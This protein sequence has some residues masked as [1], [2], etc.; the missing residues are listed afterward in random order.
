MDKISI[1][2]A[3]L[4]NFPELAFPEALLVW[5][6]R[7][8]VDIANPHEGPGG[9]LAMERLRTA[10]DH[11]RAP[12]VAAQLDHLWT[13]IGSSAKRQ[14]D[15]RCPGCITLSPDEILFVR[16]IACRQRRVT[17]G[18]SGLL[19]SLCPATARRVAA[20]FTQ[21]LADGLAEGRLLLPAR[22]DG[23]LCLWQ[24]R[25]AAAMA[26]NGEAEDEDAPALDDRSLD[27]T[28][29]GRVITLH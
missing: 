4:D 28:P 6:L 16:E 15:V 10:F 8:W 26:A 23:A 29:R 18:P 9:R 7:V 11:A 13:I 24:G 14:I 5:A 12:G 25:L 1:S 27:E 2:Y 19:A 22:P 3:D 17:P 21:T 20:P